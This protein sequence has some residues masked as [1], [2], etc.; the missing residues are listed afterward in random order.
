MYPI[1]SQPFAF[2]Y[3]NFKFYLY[4]DQ[5][6]VAKGIAQWSKKA[7][8]K[9]GKQRFNAFSSHLIHRIQMCYCCQKLEIWA[10]EADFVARG[11][12]SKIDYW[13]LIGLERSHGFWREAECGKRLWIGPFC[14]SASRQKSCDLSKP[15][16][17]AISPWLLVGLPTTFWEFFFF[18]NYEP[19]CW[20]TVLTTKR[21][22]KRLTTCSTRHTFQRKYSMFAF[23][24]QIHSSGSRGGGQGGHALPPPPGL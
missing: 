2:H 8:S 7:N 5:G 17:C 24:M 21:F 23:A 12:I 1:Y 18:D 14:P 4:Q 13:L 22:I 3:P 15:I 6:F 19:G 20:P 10:K 9:G 11:R 16:R